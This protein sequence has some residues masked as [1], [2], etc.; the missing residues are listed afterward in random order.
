MQTWPGVVHGIGVAQSCDRNRVISRASPGKNGTVAVCVMTAV[1]P[2]SPRAVTSTL[3]AGD[4]LGRI[5]SVAGSTARLPIVKLST[6]GLPRSG[7]TWISM[8]FSADGTDRSVSTRTTSVVPLFVGLHATADA[9]ASPIANVTRGS[10]RINRPPCGTA[11]CRD[12]HRP[13]RA[14]RRRCP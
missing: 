3:N 14:S 4:P 11:R 10:R 5:A 2:T 9:S 1:L 13:R 8:R 6:D 12:S 7:V